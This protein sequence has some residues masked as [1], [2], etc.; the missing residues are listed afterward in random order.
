M[1]EKQLEEFWQAALVEVAINLAPGA[2]DRWLKPLTPVSFEN[3]TLTLSTDNSV[4]VK[5]FEDKY[6]DFT[7]DACRE[8]CH[9]LDFMQNLE[10]D[11]NIQIEYHPVETPP[12]LYISIP[13]N[14]WL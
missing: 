3:N 2:I 10:G 4:I 11:I 8:A 12:P 5:F 7:L 14:H 1:V 6:K 13:D 9:K